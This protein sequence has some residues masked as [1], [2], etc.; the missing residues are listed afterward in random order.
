MHK[1]KFLKLLPLKFF[2]LSLMQNNDSSS[3]TNMLNYNNL[4]IIRL[5]Y[6]FCMATLSKVEP[7]TLYLIICIEISTDLVVIGKTLLTN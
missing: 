3:S 1:I 4:K 5:F 7:L 6:L 2:K